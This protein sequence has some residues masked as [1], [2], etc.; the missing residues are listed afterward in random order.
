VDDQD[1]R[2]QPGRAPRAHSGNH[3]RDAGAAHGSVST[4]SL[5]RTGARTLRR[6]ALVFSCSD[7]AERRIHVGTAATTRSSALSRCSPAGVT[8]VHA[9]RRLGGCDPAWQGSAEAGACGVGIAIVFLLPGIMMRP[10]D[11]TPYIVVYCGGALL[12][13][14]SCGLVLRMTALWVLRHAESTFE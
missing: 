4:G 12:V 14:L 10:A 2:R 5:S 8:W 9:R 6:E 1:Q 13:G 3:T 7:G 11:A